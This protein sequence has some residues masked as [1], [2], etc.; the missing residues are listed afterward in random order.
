MITIALI[1]PKIPQN[2][3]TIA[4]TCAA[5]HWDLHLVGDLGFSLDDKYLKR[6]GLDYWDYVSYQLF[7]S[8][9]EYLEILKSKRCHLLT[10]KSSNIYTES[11]FKKGDVLIFGSETDGVSSDFHHDFSDCSYTIP[12]AEDGIRSLNLAVSVGI[13][14]FEALRQIRGPH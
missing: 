13:V 7:P 4:R 12:M 11:T 14:G 1:Q 6:A 9:T 3:G 8:E 2:T 10:T 5:N